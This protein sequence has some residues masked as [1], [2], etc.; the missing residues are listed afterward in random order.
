M[1]IKAVINK[2]QQAEYQTQTYS[3]EDSIRVSGVGKQGCYG[4]LSQAHTPGQCSQA[5]GCAASWKAGHRLS[6]RRSLET[7]QDH[8]ESLR[9]SLALGLTWP[10]SLEV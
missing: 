4:N 6:N 1:L 2:S 3:A 9:P 5:A 8:L 10:S 7:H